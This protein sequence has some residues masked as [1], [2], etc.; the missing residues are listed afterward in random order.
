MRGEQLLACD[1]AGR[2]L[3]A[4]P[5]NLELAHQLVFALLQSG[6]RHEA[7][8]R[9]HGLGLDQHLIRPHIEALRAR[10]LK[11]EAFD[12]SGI[13][14]REALRAAAAAYRRLFERHQDPWF[15]VNAAT[16]RRLSEDR[17]T[18][19]TLIRAVLRLTNPQARRGMGRFMAWAIRAE[20]HLLL[21]ESEH[22]RAALIAARRTLRR[23]SAPDYAT[24]AG[25]RVQ[26]RRLLP[27]LGQ[28]DDTWLSLITPP[29]VVFYCGRSIRTADRAGARRQSALRARIEA[30]LERRDIGFGYGSLAAGADILCG[31]A[32]LERGAE[33]HVLLPFPDSSF[34]AR[35]VEPAGRAWRRRFDR[36]LAGAQSVTVANEDGDPG[37]AAL[38]R[39]GMDLGVGM[40][41]LRAQNLDAP[42]HQL[43]L[44]DGAATG[45]TATLIERWRRLGWSPDVLDI[46]AALGP[47]GEVL[48]AGDST[49]APRAILFGD[50][51]GFTELAEERLPAF[52]DR[53][54][55]GFAAVLDAHDDAVLF[56]NTWG[57]GLFAVIRD[58]PSAADIARGLHASLAR[59]GD[60]AER[61]RLRLGLHF[62]PVMARRDPV[63]GRVNYFGRHVS[64][65]ARIEPITP[66]GQTYVTEEF[67]AQLLLADR[68]C[69]PA[70]YVGEVPA[71][72][73]YGKLRMYVLPD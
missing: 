65:T 45:G 73:G 52:V 47:G 23:L 12:G 44:T 3:E 17:G 26:L 32:L 58:A 29:G 39:Y 24:L 59:A 11:E 70:E 67:A 20:G 27:V 46:G 41:L 61:L 30:Y 33:L 68:H 54:L 21:G 56:R 66:P 57:D 50:V 35:F 8:R 28:P 14:D 53:A 2:G 22:A 10:L 7:W 38:Y 72:K 5:G 55:G 25:V 60:I 48:P 37:D 15:G 63:L 51:R 31:E 34:A 42:L 18:P 6:A 49:H 69:A 1:L 13:A 4:F 19:R 62:G 64:R 40:A 16:L 71:A 9:F 43:A 36:C